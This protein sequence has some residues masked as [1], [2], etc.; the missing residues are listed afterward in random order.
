MGKGGSDDA[1]NQHFG[2]APAYTVFDTDTGEYS[3]VV[4]NGSEGPAD[5]MAGVGVNVMLCG[6]IGKGASAMLQQRGIDVFIGASGMIKDAIDAWNSGALSKNPNGNCNS[7]EHDDN[8]DECSSN[9]NCHS[10]VTIS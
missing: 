7:H 1:V 2:R 9:C 3:V 8:H 10:H 5:L 6:G 4:R